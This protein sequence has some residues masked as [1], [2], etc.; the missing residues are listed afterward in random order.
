MLVSPFK[1]HTDEVLF[2]TGS[3]QLFTMN[4]ESFDV[5][6]YKSKNVES[7]VEER[8]NGSFT[9]GQLGAERPSEVVFMKLDR[10]RWDTFSFKNVKAMTTQGASR[11]GASILRYGTVIINGF[12]HKIFFQP[13]EG[14]DNVEVNNKTY[15]VAYVPD[16]DGRPVVGLLTK[17]SDEYRA[18]L[19]Q[20]DTIMAIDGKAVATFADFRRYP[21]VEGQTYTLTVR[22]QNGMERQVPFTR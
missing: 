22:G 1:R 15:T 18:G 7:Q 21:F 10:L 17:S 6:A 19:R 16:R 12:R 14:G 20:G 13:Y 8:V 2:D 3:P 4:K 9:I 5:H 11:I